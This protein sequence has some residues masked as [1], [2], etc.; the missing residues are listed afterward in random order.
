MR[1]ELE[2][3]VDWNKLLR[4]SNAWSPYEA[5]RKQR[6]RLVASLLLNGLLVILLLMSAR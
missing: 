1:S 5:L 3:T 2:K 6:W 4:Q